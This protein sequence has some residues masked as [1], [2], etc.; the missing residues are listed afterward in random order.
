MGF[1][2]SD[3]A[4]DGVSRPLATERG[5]PVDRVDPTLAV[6]DAEAPFDWPCHALLEPPPILT[7]NGVRAV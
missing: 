6:P 4:G 3:L 2:A 5:G 7:V 1:G